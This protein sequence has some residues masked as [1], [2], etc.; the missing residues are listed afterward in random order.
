MVSDSLYSELVLEESRHPH[1]E[2]VAA[3]ADVTVT[4]GVASCGDVA[5]VGLKITDKT[6][7][8]MSWE[9]TGC[10]ISRAS[11]SLLSSAVE[12]QSMAAVANWTIKD[13]LSLLHLEQISPGRERC[14]LLGL[15]ALQRALTEYQHKKESVHE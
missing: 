4:E 7:E 5:V 6:I 12:G 1:N 3:D 10:A 11:I 13:V 2:G 9:A 8:K 14:L 15:R